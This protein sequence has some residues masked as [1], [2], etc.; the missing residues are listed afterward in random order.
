[1]SAWRT[2]CALRDRALIRA[3]EGDEPID[4]RDAVDELA[5]IREQLDEALATEPDVGAAFAELDA[6][7]RADADASWAYAEALEGSDES[8]E[9]YSECEQTKV[10]LSA[11]LDAVRAIAGAPR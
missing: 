11:A 9:A 10:R 6:A 8:A 5:A 1:M 7:M 3:T 2:L 4:G